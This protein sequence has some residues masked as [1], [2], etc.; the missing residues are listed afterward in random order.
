MSIISNLLPN[1]IYLQISI[2]NLM[3]IDMKE[4]LLMTLTSK[5]FIDEIKP[6]MLKISYSKIQPGSQVYCELLDKI[7]E[8]VLKGEEEWKIKEYLKSLIK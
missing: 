4:T 5:E 7:K 1:C 6:D 3:L 8:K 2:D